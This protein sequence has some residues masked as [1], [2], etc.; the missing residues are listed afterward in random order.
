MTVRDER[1]V[2]LDWIM[3]V[4]ESLGKDPFRTDP[5]PDL[6]CIDP[7]SELIGYA[8]ALTD[9]ENAIRERLFKIMAGVA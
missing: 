6:A 7:Q 9:L 5:E 8:Y 4:I 3:D 2:E 1:I